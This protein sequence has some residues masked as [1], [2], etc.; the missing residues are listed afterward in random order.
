M[1]TTTAPHRRIRLVSLALLI[2]LSAFTSLIVG[3]AQIA[4]SSPSL[5]VQQTDSSGSFSVYYE[6]QYEQ[7]RPVVQEENSLSAAIL[8]AVTEAQAW[9][10]FDPSSLADKVAAVDAAT[11]EAK[12]WPDSKT[13]GFE[14]A[15]ILDRFPDFDLAGPCPPCAVP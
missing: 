2:I 12:T 15:S 4:A 14:E 8:A 1:R 10:N 5:A 7:G 3:P 13:S 6:L 11:K 9:P